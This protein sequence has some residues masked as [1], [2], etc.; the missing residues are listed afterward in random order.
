MIHYHTNR[1]IN[2]GQYI[3][4][5]Q[6][7]SLGARR[8]LTERA[9]IDA[10]LHHADLL[11]TAWQDEALIGL[12]RALTDYSYCC[13]LSDL[14]VDEAYQRR[15]IGRGLLDELAAALQPG[16]KIILLAAPQAADYYPHIGYSQHPGAWTKTP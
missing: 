8:P 3:A 13:Y 9:R 12:A 7:T 16:C 4:L 14:A 2:G 15:G 11:I 1:P 10:M 5:L 6:K